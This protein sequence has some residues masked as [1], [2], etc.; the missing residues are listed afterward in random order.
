MQC[1]IRKKAAHGELLFFIYLKFVLRFHRL[2]YLFDWIE[3]FRRKITEVSNREHLLGQS[4]FS[5]IKYVK[6]EYMI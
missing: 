1:K 6:M 2:A 5:I 4:R 3:S